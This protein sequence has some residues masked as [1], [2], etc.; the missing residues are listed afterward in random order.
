MGGEA[1]GAARPSLPA[2]VKIRRGKPNQ[3]KSSL[4]KVNQGKKVTNDE[5]RMTK[6]GRKNR[7][8]GRG[9][10]AFVKLRRG[11]GG[12]PAVRLGRSRHSLD[13]TPLAVLPDGVRAGRA[14][15][16]GAGTELIRPDPT[17][18]RQGYGAASPPSLKLP[19]SPAYGTSRRGKPIGKA[20]RQLC[21]THKPEKNIFFGVQSVFNLPFN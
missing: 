8:G 19:P 10:P 6:A 1:D 15:Q 13:A 16:S 2:Y 9:R 4:I 7:G 14:V 17:R 3:A 20:K 11:K 18:L 21:P 12:L 5:I